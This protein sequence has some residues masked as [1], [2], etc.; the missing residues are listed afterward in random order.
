LKKKKDE[1]FVINLSYQIK[2]SESTNSFENNHKLHDIMIKRQ[3]SKKSF[4]SRNLESE[5]LEQ[6]KKPRRNSNANSIKRED[7][8]KEDYQFLE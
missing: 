1:N 6:K 2:E 7:Q 3:D 4:N 5:L 8:K